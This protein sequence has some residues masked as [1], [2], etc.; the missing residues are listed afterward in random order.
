M[1]V[2][3]QPSDRWENAR[4]LEILGWTDDRDAVSHLMKA[5]ASQETG[6][7]ERA[8][9]AKSLATLGA[10]EHSELY[11]AEILDKSVNEYY[12]GKI[13]GAVT[14]PDAK[15]TEAVFTL[16]RD[17]TDDRKPAAGS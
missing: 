15:F 7:D 14:V 10:S 4:M 2:A 1:I 8:I 17:V 5:A 6:P 13:A 3:W 16:V 12:R 11:V 9:I